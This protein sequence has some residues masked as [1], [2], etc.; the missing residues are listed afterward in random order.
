MIPIA[1][2]STSCVG[3]REHN[4]DCI[5][6]ARAADALCCVL[7]DGAGG[8]GGGAIASR[9]AVDQILE[10]FRARP[11]SDAVDLGELILDAHEAI[12]RRQ[13]EERGP[14]SR[15]HATIVV[16]VIDETR[17][18]AIWG[19]VGDS[20]LYLLSGGAVQ[21]VTHD[22]SIVQWMIDAGHLE[23]EA[24]RSHP[25]KNQLFAAL[26]MSDAVQPQTSG[27]EVALREGDALL[28][29]SDGWWEHV[30]E[31]DILDSMVAARSVDDWLERMAAVIVERNA[32]QQDNY[33]AIAVWVGDP[34]RTMYVAPDPG[35][36]DGPS[37][38]AP[39]V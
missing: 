28:I 24:A 31:G 20:R 19:H 38:L 22:D 16:L 32:P 23:P 35:P 37:D 21:A 2:A 18:G 7:A 11:P 27:S 36:P 9:V 34:N 33:S 4:E 39:D 15:M 14:A 26:G 25:H 5:A 12:L 8:H 1:V 17:A 10:G 30:S 13:R 29:C 6:T 3:A